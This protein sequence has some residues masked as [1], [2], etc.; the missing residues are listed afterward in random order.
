[1]AVYTLGSNILS[2]LGIGDEPGSTHVPLEITFFSGMKID[3]V[4][5]GSL[6]T[7]VLSTGRVF[8]FGCNDE[9][10]LGRDGDENVPGEV[11]LPE[12][13][14]RVG[15]GQSC[16]FCIGTSGRLY[17]W[18]TFRDQGGVI[19]FRPGMRMQ[20]VPAMVHRGPVR[21]LAVGGNHVLFSVR[22]EVYALGS[23]ECGEKGVYRNRRIGKIREL[24]T[25]LVANRRS[26]HSK[27]TRMF[28]GANTSFMVSERGEAYAFGKN[29]DGQLGT[30][31]RQSGISKRKVPL[32]GIRSVS[33]GE[34]HTLF[35]TR[36]GRL[37]VAGNNTFGQLG[38]GDS[39]DRDTLTC[40]DMPGVMRAKTK[41]FFSVAQT[42]TGMY[43]W[44]FNTHGECGY[45]GGD[46]NVPR[47][48]E[49]ERVAMFDV[50]HDFCVFVV[51]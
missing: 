34:L 6:H 27:C 23:N 38:T 33:S 20:R 35:V 14:V 40:L 8:S 22:G 45:D 36:D 30:G 7:L 1:M 39:A 46:S 32:D 19:G 44:G 25:V 9:C 42:E 10:A 2:Q 28:C 18:G 5:C 12:P 16:S 4:C 37:Y 47:K 3:Q 41:G 48:M 50:G 17:G 26:R 49:L 24:G 43:S 29:T 13:A 31:D 51:E 15:A 11:V 21:G